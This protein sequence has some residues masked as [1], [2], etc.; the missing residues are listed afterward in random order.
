MNKKRPFGLVFCVAYLAYCSIYVARLN[1]S[2]ASAL[3]EADHILNK[4]QIGLIGGVFSFVYAIAKVPNGYLGDRSS[5]RKMIV[6]GLLITG[7]SNLAIGVSPR[8]PGI[9]FAWGINAF[10]QSMIWGPLLRM[11]SGTYGENRL[12]TVSQFLVSSVAAGSI[13]GLLA[14]SWCAS[15]FGAAACFLIPGGIA[16]VMAAVSGRLLED[17]PGEKQNR[18]FLFR[19][20]VCRLYREPHFRKLVFPAL[21]HGMLKDNINVWL[22]LYLVDTYGVRAE[23]IAGYIFFVPFFAF[24]GRLL[25]PAL[26]QKWKNEYKISGAAFVLCA[27]MSAALC[28]RKLPMAAALLC[29]GGISAMVSVINTHML[30]VFPAEF[31]ADGYLSFA[32]SVM[33]LL[34]YCGAGIGSL[35]FGVLI[36][37]CGYAG[38]FFV[39]GAV[40]AVSALAMKTSREWKREEIGK[41]Q[42]Q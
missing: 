21:A 33:D 14:A 20:A 22:A 35:L 23:S 8:F 32:A 25:Y 42:K 38:M 6:C 15:A 36:Q 19:D 17:V 11:F 18:A 34:T 28:V 31:A 41:I 40:S 1:F 12:K 16:L 27:A 7:V 29:L 39:W 10:G 9:V 26:F 24:V 30:S 5:S 3:L 4:P 13:L 2:V 37:N